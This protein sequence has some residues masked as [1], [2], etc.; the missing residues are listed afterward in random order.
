MPTKEPNGKQ[1]NLASDIVLRL[2][3]KVSIR[4]EKVDTISAH[5]SIFDQAGHIAVGKFGKPWSAEKCSDYCRSVTKSKRPR[6]IIVTRSGEKLFGWSAPLETVFP[7]DDKRAG[8]LARPRYYDELANQPSLFATA[9][10]SKP[11]MWF[12]V[13]EKFRPCSLSNLWLASNG[14]RLSSVLRETRTAMMLVTGSPMPKLT[15]SR[16]SKL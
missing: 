2:S 5:N 4:S 15:S 3:A 7:A 11:T 1:T 16:K 12:V 9:L 6:L 10:V 8:R 14:R 13:T